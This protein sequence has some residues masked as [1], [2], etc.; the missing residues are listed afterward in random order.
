LIYQLWGQT[1]H[2]YTSILYSPLHP[3]SY[4]VEFFNFSVPFIELLPM[5]CPYSKCFNIPRHTF[6]HKLPNFHNLNLKF[7]S[8]VWISKNHQNHLLKILYNLLHSF[9]LFLLSLPSFQAN[10]KLCFFIVC[11]DRPN[12]LNFHS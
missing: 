4:W 12:I 2:H 3:I 7:I 6:P 11:I 1:I 5:K 8:S 9:R 10:Q